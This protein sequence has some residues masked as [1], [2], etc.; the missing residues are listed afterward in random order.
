M[1]ITLLADGWIPNF[2]RG[3]ASIAWTLSILVLVVKQSFMSCYEC[4]VFWIG[5]LHLQKFLTL[6][7]AEDTFLGTH[8]E[9]TFDMPECS[10][11]IVYTCHIV[12]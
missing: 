8:M 7:F 9:D 6:S 10:W 4:E 5:I 12:I 1:A 2:L 3:G 11:I